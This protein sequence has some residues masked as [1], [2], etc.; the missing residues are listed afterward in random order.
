MRIAL[1]LRFMSSI[2]LEMNLVVICSSFA[3]TLGFV[4][5]RYL[6]RS[7]ASFSNRFTSLFFTTLVELLTLNEIQAS[8]A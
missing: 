6:L 7:S 3:M 5:A 8:A 2:V 4:P 1:A